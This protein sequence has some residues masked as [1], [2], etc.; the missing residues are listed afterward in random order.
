MRRVS[1][2]YA[3]NR[4][5]ASLVQQQELLGKLRR[6]EPDNYGAHLSAAIIAFVHRRDVEEA[7]RDID[8]CKGAAD[9]A[10]CYNEAFL[11]GYEGNLDAAYRSYLR[12]FDSPLMDLT[13]PAQSEEFILG[14]I[15]QEPERYWLYFCLGMI[16][17]RYKG[18]M[19]SA[20]RDLQMFLDRAEP[21]RFGRQIAAVEK[22]IEEIDAT[23]GAAV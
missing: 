12:A 20:R 7:R 19:V 8:A 10:W 3:R 17:H 14:I 16:N 5:S 2:G 9:G 1:A 11:I 13:V 23:R 15:D 22:W 6:Y 18:D 21:A 4:D